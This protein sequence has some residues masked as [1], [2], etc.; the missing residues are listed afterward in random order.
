MVV[1]VSRAAAPDPSDADGAVSGTR[2]SPRALNDA[3]PDAPILVEC[4]NFDC[5]VCG[6]FY[7]VIEQFRADY[8]GE[9]NYVVR[10]F[11]LPGHFNSMNAALAFKAAAQRGE[12][13]EMYHRLP[14]VPRGGGLSGP[15]RRDR[16]G[17]SHRAMVSENDQ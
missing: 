5:E 6:A 13:E 8:A 2:A 15:R 9:I 11:L 3:V 16:D 12:F 4:L 14:G 10:S 7:T 17:V 1:M